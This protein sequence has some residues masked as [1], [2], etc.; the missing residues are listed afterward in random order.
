[1]KARILCV[2]DNPVNWRLVQRLLT[3]SGYE[4]HWAEEGMAGFQMAIELK[5]DLILLDINLPGLSGFEVATKLRQHKDTARIVVVALTAKTQKSDRETALVAGCDGF[6]S[7]PIDPFAF[8]DQVAAYLAGK[9]DRLEESREGHALRQFSH[10]VVEHLEAQLKDAQDANRKLMSAQNAL[11]VRNRSLSRLLHLSRA[12]L[13]E[14]D[15]DE[16]LRN[17]IRAIVVELELTHVIAYR[18]DSSRGFLEGLRWCAG[19][20]ER[21]QPLPA[22]A[23]FPSRLSRSGLQTPLVGEGLEH[24]RFWD[25]GVGL[26]LWAQPAQACLLPLRGSSADQP[27]SGFLAMIR[28]GDRPFQAADAELVAL[29]GGMAQAGLENAGLIESLNESS[30]ALASSYERLESAYQELQVAR[31]ALGLK[32]R[33]AVLGEIFLN[34]AQRLERP[35]AV[36][37]QECATLNRI[38]EFRTRPEARFWEEDAPNALK[39][40]QNACAQMDTLV[41]ALLRRAGKEA[42]ATPEWLNLHEFITQ[43][44]LFLDADGSIPEGVDVGLELQAEERSIF[45]VYGDF[46]E[47]LSKLV[48]HALGG[49]DQ[50]QSLLIR[51]TSK[52][53]AFHMEVLDEGGAIL[54]ER[55]RTAFEPFTALHALEPVLGVRSPGEGLPACTQILAAYQGTLEILNEGDGTL[56]VMELPLR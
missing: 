25:E 39:G 5:P 56:V 32:E 31:V 16:L 46:A 6:I 54:P 28:A 1:M 41:Q 3:Q 38:Q 33:Q 44:I 51:T 11:E 42:P 48:A 19:T 7:K 9:R 10:Q 36:L 24:S 12:V 30:R 45:G 18:M 29:H 49:P 35:V 20:F 50:T 14:H 37:L 8:V 21:L 26:G 40:I 53:G 13:A 34:M 47:I 43:E 55:L 52:A 27:F 23:D 22:E 15:A 17:T 2:E 4:M